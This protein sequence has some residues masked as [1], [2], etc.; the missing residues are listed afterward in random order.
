[1]FGLWHSYSS[2]HFTAEVLR[3]LI[4]I[5]PWTGRSIPE[6][7]KNIKT[8]KLTFPSE[9][10][11]SDGVKDM[12][13]GCLRLKEEDRFSWDQIF[14]HKCFGDSFKSYL[15]HEKELE[16]KLSSISE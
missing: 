5:A 3:P 11:V 8:Q 7:V 10:E 1:M 2:R 9:V 13:S 6:L 16:V 15:I 14:R 12:I 4:F